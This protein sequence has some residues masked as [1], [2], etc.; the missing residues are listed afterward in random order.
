MVENEPRGKLIH[1]QS[2]S[3]LNKEAQVQN[4]GAFLHFF[5][6]G[7]GPENKQHAVRR[8]RELMFA[9]FF[10]KDGKYAS[11]SL[12]PILSICSERAGSARAWKRFL[13]PE[14]STTNPKQSES[15]Y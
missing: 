14:I 2:C 12:V 11:S 3:K 5:F 15:S 9:I 10:F 1:K 7:F 8:R 13:K 6:A 4:S